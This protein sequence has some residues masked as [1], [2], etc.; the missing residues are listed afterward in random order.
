MSKLKP[1][2]IIADSGRRKRGGGGGFWSFLAFL[3]VFAVGIY[4]GTKLDE[5][6]ITGSGDNQQSA[7]SESSSSVT[8]EN[9]TDTESK[10][11]FSQETLSSKEPAVIISEKIQTG[12]SIGDD[13]SD[14]GDSDN[15][16]GYDTD[17]GLVSLDPEDIS[18]PGGV[19]ID[20]NGVE[21]EDTVD[22]EETTAEGEQAE[23]ANSGANG[24]TLQI[25]AF[26]TPQEAEKVMN[27]YNGKGYDAYTVKITNS[28]GEEWN[29]VKI[30]RFRTIERAWDES[31][32]FKRREGQEAYVE[33]L[34]QDT[35]VNESLDNSEE[36]DQ[37][38][39]HP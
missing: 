29:L 38:A 10:P 21:N 5:Y 6:G 15:A 1:Q 39:V 19:D 3:I 17:S 22:S 18:S 13:V 35:K 26:A 8:T 12:E 4:V 28:R 9:V 32:V 31:A 37:S 33:T 20:E 7:V 36:S 11:D 23:T 2:L 30:G 34:N 24:Y 14:L 25:A 16:D 27:E